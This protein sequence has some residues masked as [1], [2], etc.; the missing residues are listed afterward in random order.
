MAAERILR[1]DVRYVLTEQGREELLHA[2]T[3]ACEDLWVVD[4]YFLCLFCHT[5]YGVVYGSSYRNGQRAASR[6][7][8]PV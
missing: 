7:V 3:C 2:P 1:K 4:G 6:R 5:A 8:V